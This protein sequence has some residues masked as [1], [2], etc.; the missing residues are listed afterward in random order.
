MS[1]L[2]ARRRRARRAKIL[3][4]A[5]IRGTA[6]SLVIRP[7]KNVVRG[8]SSTSATEWAGF[9]TATSAVVAAGAAIY[10]PVGIGLAVFCF[11]AGGSLA[12]KKGKNYRAPDIVTDAEF[13]E[14]GVPED[15]VPAI[16][17]R[18]FDDRFGTWASR[19][20]ESHEIDVFHFYKLI[21]RID[22]LDYTSGDF[23]SIRRLVVQNATESVSDGIVYVENSERKC[24]FPSTEVE[25]FQSETSKEL[26]VKCLNDLKGKR[27]RHAF[28]ILFPAPL[29]I[30]ETFDLAYRIKLPGELTDLSDE[31]EV[32]SIFLGRATRGVEK[33]RFEVCLNFHPRAVSV[34]CEDQHGKTAAYDGS[35][36]I[37]ASFEPQAWLEKKWNI[38]WSA[39][40][41]CRISIDVDSPRN[42]LYI[43]HY[44]K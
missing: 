1:K 41:P 20:S 17:E 33:L 12:H 7:Y 14:I 34:T 28:K 4:V 21:H 2:P 22:L 44:K 31:D 13:L 18:E 35:E 38:R 37:V 40:T 6:N 23:Y 42:Y 11:L 10:P 15:Q 19:Y 16:R 43:V 29:A 27:F 3:V 30:G 25:A 26:I 32:M 39:V 24:T 36:P 8:I 5:H 9:F